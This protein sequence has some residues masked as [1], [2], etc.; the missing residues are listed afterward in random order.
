MPTRHGQRDK[1]T[2]DLLLPVAHETLLM[3]SEQ[4]LVN[5]IREAAVVVDRAERWRRLVESDGDDSL[6]SAEAREIL[7]D[8][9]YDVWTQV[10]MW[11]AVHRHETYWEDLEGQNPR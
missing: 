2:D 8:R 6:P 3:L 1:G 9:F 10:Q 5:L 7:R 4:N 11:H